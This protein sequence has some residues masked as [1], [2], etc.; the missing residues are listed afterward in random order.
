[1][2]PSSLRIIPEEGK[3]RGTETQT[4]GS[5]SS[6]QAS[7]AHPS[8]VPKARH[9]K[10]AQ[11]P[12]CPQPTFGQPAVLPPPSWAWQQHWVTQPQAGDND[13]TVGSRTS[14]AAERLRIIHQGVTSTHSAEQPLPP[15]CPASS[16]KALPTPPCD[17]GR[18]VSFL[19]FPCSPPPPPLTPQHTPVSICTVHHTFP[20]SLPRS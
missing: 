4:D 16:P 18:G 8:P 12:R 7:L 20:A 2:T 11:S 14:T 13:H 5:G 3:S 15:L 1:M 19:G 9:T 17:S 10:E 6:Q